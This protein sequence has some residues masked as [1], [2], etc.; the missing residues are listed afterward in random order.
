MSKKN[1]TKPSKLKKREAAK[2]KKAMRY[3]K[4]AC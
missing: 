1:P 4:D 2:A 3:G